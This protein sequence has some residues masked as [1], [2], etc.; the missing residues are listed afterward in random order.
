MK[1]R[2][3]EEQPKTK[4]VKRNSSTSK[5]GDIRH[6]LSHYH[7]NNV[8]SRCDGDRPPPLIICIES[9]LPVLW[10][11]PIEEEQ[12]VFVCKKVWLVEDKE[13]STSQIPM[14][15]SSDFFHYFTSDDVH[16]STE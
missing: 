1:I 13:N 16:Y 5:T 7:N 10:M 4:N 11:Q 15:N 14:T 2:Y 3:D 8:G 6:H 9:Q 12:P